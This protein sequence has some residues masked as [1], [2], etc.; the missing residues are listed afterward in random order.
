M[1]INTPLLYNERSERQHNNDDSFERELLDLTC[2]KVSN[3]T[4]RGE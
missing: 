2:R 3:L 1:C 4:G